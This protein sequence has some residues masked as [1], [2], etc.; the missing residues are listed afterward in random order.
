MT[1]DKRITVYD[2][3]DGHC[4]YCGREIGLQDMQIDHIKPK[5]TW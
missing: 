2:K 1:K 3:Y 5:R 4:A